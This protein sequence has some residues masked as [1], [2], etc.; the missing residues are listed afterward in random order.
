[1]RARNS[2]EPSP[3]IRSH[4]K[5]HNNLGV[6]QLRLDRLE[7]AAAEFRVALAAEARNVES[8]VNLALVH[9]ASGRAPESREL[10]QRAVEIDLRHAGSH[11]NLAVVADEEGDR[12][13]AVQ[14]YRAFLRFRT[15]S[16]GELTG[17]R[18]ITGA[19]LLAV[20]LQRLASV[21]LR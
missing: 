11:Y 12:A 16:H 5:A 4:V 14:H 1:L 20:G 8:I 6:L 7:E 2:R 17:S 15:V 13:T 3:S 9:R 18:A 10:L 21:G 19:G